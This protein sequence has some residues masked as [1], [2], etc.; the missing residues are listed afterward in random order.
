MKKYVFCRTGISSTVSHTDYVERILGQG[1]LSSNQVNYLLL[2]CV[3]IT[4]TTGVRELGHAISYVA[5]L[6]TSDVD[7]LLIF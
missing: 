2:N 7:I 3:F 6:K 5:F 1:T 4:A